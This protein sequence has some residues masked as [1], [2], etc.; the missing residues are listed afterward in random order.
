MWNRSEVVNAPLSP[1]Q[2]IR[3]A[4]ERSERYDRAVSR[5]RLR[6][7]SLG[8]RSL[9]AALAITAALPAVAEAASPWQFSDF[10]LAGGTRY[11]LTV[12]KQQQLPGIDPAISPKG[13]RFVCSFTGPIVRHKVNLAYGT[14]DYAELRISGS[15]K[16]ATELTYRALGNGQSFHIVGTFGNVPRTVDT[17]LNIAGLVSS[18]ADA[19]K[20][21]AAPLLGLYDFQLVPYSAYYL[22]PP[23]YSIDL[24]AATLGAKLDV[25]Q[26]T[27]AECPTPAALPTTY[28][29]AT[30]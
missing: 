30:R 2:R 27:D 10:R 20:A 22:I 28:F 11:T 19:A 7:L 16:K 13:Y 4:P 6:R 15:V 23:Y 24:P 25:R 14:S 5:R 17:K 3:V 21:P 8:R 1:A 9:V 26:G 12:S 29:R 18:T